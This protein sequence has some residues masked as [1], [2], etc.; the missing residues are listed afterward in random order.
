MMPMLITVIGHFHLW[1][2]RWNRRML[3]TLAMIAAMPIG[4]PSHGPTPAPKPIS[5]KTNGIR[6]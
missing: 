6:T 1:S 4:T 2:A 3:T 5:G